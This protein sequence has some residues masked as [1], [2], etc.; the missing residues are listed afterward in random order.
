M[1]E[2]VVVF[3]DAEVM[4]HESHSGSWVPL[5]GQRKA[6]V[7]VV[8]NG[9]NQQFR[10]IAMLDETLVLNTRLYYKMHYKAATTTFHQWRDEQKAVYGL[11]FASQDQARQ[12]EDMVRQVLELI[13]RLRDM[14][15]EN[16]G[17]TN[18]YDQQA[19]YQEPHHQNPST[20]HHMHSAPVLR[21][22]DD[23]A[24]RNRTLGASQQQQQQIRRSSQGSSHSGNGSVYAQVSN[25]HVSSPPRAVPTSSAAVTGGP[26][27]P[28]PPPPISGLPPVSTNAPPPP[29]PPPPSMLT[30]GTAG[31]SLADQLKNATLKKVERKESNSGMEE[32]Q[33]GSNGTA[34]AGGVTGDLMRELAATMSKR[35]NTRA[36]LDAVDSK[37]NVSNGSSDS[38]CGIIAPPPLSSTNASS[39]STLNGGSVKKWPDPIKNGVDM[40][41]KKAPSTSSICSEDVRKHSNGAEISPEVYER[42]KADILSEIRVELDKVK[43]E[44]LAAIQSSSNH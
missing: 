7:R 40:G 3:A 28:P 25:G 42:L 17:Y 32:K 29:P 11:S 36:Q 43:N 13:A 30:G 15:V 1:G 10:I 26:P 20:M 23:P 9:R 6:S 18:G 34:P 35:K 44:I 16:G 4:Q 31:K 12:F 41:H 33:N 19:V 37:S 14:P 2:S 22:E 24:L 21:S 5:S 38:G 39:N 8:Q 27:A